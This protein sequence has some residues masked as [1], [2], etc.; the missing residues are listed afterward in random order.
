MTDETTD[1]LFDE[2]ATAEGIDPDVLRA[3][4]VHLDEEPTRQV[5]RE[6]AEVYEGEFSTDDEF[7]EW[8]FDSLGEDIPGMVRAHIDWGSVWH[9]E[10]R[11]DYFEVEGHYFRNV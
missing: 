11:H 1:D 5:A 2:V 7:A 8:L 9:C 3:Y 4:C 10:L 6:C